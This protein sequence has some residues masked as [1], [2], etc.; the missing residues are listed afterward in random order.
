MQ[1]ANELARRVVE[2][3]GFE[4]FDPFA[5]GMHASAKWYDSSGKDNQ[6]SDVLSDVVLQMLLAQI[7]GSGGR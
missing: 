4:V 1:V 7:C 5:A 3:A 2:G 6:H